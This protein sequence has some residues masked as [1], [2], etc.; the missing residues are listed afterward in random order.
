M[1]QIRS[2]IVL[3]LVGPSGS[4]KSTV[5]SYLEKEYGFRRTHVA[6]RLKLAF[7]TLF[8]CGA[9][10][11]EQPD[12]ERPAAFLGGIAPRAILEHLGNTLHE[13]APLALPL[14][15]SRRIEQM[16]TSYGPG[17]DNG[18]RILVDGI[19]RQTEADLVYSFGGK[20]IRMLG[21]G[22]DPEKPC[23]ISQQAVHHDFTLTWAPALNELHERVDAILEELGVS[24]GGRGSGSAI[25][26]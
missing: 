6:A 4:G 13:V 2:P 14:T 21:Q 3:G 22:V 10:N 15:A 25:A 24:N 8:D 11:T 23:D 16:I 19:R 26:A 7:T 5:C 20:M 12:I 1:S 9:H 18:P 17:D